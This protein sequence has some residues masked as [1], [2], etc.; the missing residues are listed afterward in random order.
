ML[1]LIPTA[2]GDRPPLFLRRDALAGGYSE[3]LICQLVKADEWHRVR[4][5]AFTLG[6]VWA[7]LDD[8]GRH[9]LKIRAVLLQA[10]TDLVVSHSSAAVWLGGPTWGLD[11]S[12]VH[13]TRRDQRAGRVAAGVHQHQGVLLDGDVVARDGVEVT[14]PT[15]TAIDVTTMLPVEAGLVQVSHLLHSAT[16]DVQKVDARAAL[17]EKDPYT[18]RTGLVTKLADQRLESVGE[19]RTYFA[20]WRHHV[21][22]PQL[23][24][25][26]CDETGRVVAR[27]DFAWPELG[28]WLEFDGRVKYEKHL[29]PGQSASDA[30]VA[31]KKREDA[32][33]R[34]T[35]WRCIRIT[36]ADL[37][38]ADKLCAMIMR[39][40]RVA[41]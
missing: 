22:L 3:K 15:K 12:V 17:M 2:D 28:V 7:E 38:D 25:E 40:L 31:E 10:R 41:A 30:V 21:P 4:H 13:V 1:E 6:A 35:G 37:Q 29:R 27:L 9:L 11:L 23:Q 36:W 16:T 19:S 39:E 32:V 5:G 8:A 24:H 14:S 18:L 34:L 33:R 20:L 26:V